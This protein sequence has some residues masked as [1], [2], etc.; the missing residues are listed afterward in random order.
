MFQIL[1]KTLLIVVAIAS[2]G[3]DLRTHR[4]PNFITFTAMVLGLVLYA[5]VGGMSGFLD[6]FGGLGIGLG[7][8]L[9]VYI[10]GGMGAGDVKL[11]GGMGSLLGVEKT[12]FALLSTALIG[13]I[14][15]IIKI[16]A[17]SSWKDTYYRFLL[18]LTVR[19]KTS[20]GQTR[21]IDERPGLTIPYGVAIGLGSIMT[22]FI[23]NWHIN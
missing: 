22:L 19:S 14:L 17:T 1:I 3:Y 12:I 11:M 23:K 13:G 2:I 15:A 16:T 9:I 20:D 7:V 18:L 6:A 5:V 10:M 8:F 21:G 4:I